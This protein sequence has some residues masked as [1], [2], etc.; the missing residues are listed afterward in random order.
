MYVGTSE[1]Y[2]IVWPKWEDRWSET[3]VKGHLWSHRITLP[4]RG[5]GGNGGGVG[6]L[7]QPTTMQPWELS[8]RR[9]YHSPHLISFEL[10][11]SKDGRAVW[12]Q[13]PFGPPPITS[14]VVKWHGTV[15]FFFFFFLELKKPLDDKW[16]MKSKIAKPL[17]SLTSTLMKMNYK[18][19]NLVRVKLLDHLKIY[20]HNKKHL[21]C[22]QSHLHWQW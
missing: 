11:N 9:L 6:H 10:N 12:Y 1:Q 16:K 5:G 17:Q 22:Q 19:S 2:F 7:S 15:T 8:P 18:N 20:Q 21:H 4:E 3:C 13:Q 14:L